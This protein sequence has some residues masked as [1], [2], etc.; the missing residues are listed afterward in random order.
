M[1]IVMKCFPVG[2]AFYTPASKS[3][4][5]FKPASRVQSS[6]SSKNL[7]RFQTYDECLSLAGL[8]TWA[9][10]QISYSHARQCLASKNL[11]TALQALARC[12]KPMFSGSLGMKK[13][14]ESSSVWW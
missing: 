4:M 12:V 11:S 5:R 1:R 7:T 8:P 2:S 10:P 6:M 13:Q 3:R 9:V 14:A